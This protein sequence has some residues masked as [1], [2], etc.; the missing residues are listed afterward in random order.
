[1]KIKVKLGREHLIITVR[2]SLPLYKSMYLW[3]KCFYSLILCYKLSNIGVCILLFHKV[4]QHKCDLEYISIRK[5]C[6]DTR[7]YKET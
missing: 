7:F 6:F 3:N 5:N 4:G 1:M 2:L